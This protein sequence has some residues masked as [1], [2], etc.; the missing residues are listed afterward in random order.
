MVFPWSPLLGILLVTAPGAQ[1]ETRLEEYQYK[2]KF[3]AF[4]AYYANYPPRPATPQV[5][6][7]GI[8][9]KSPFGRYIDEAFGPTTTIKGRRVQVVYPKNEKEAAACEVLFICRS[10]Q[11]RLDEILGW[12]RGLPILTVGDTKG[13]A[14]QGV[15]VNFFLEQSFVRTEVNLQAARKV[16]MDFNSAFLKNSRVVTAN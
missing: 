16:G 4:A 1:E 6:V 9:G 2:A 11:G 3:L 15:M 12:V 14:N 10:E 13:F 5:W 8:F 7:I